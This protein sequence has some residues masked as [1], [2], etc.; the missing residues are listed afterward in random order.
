MLIRVG[1]SPTMG[2][3]QDDDATACHRVLIVYASDT[4][5]TAE[6]A[7]R[8]YC[9]Q[10]SDSDAVVVGSAICAGLEGWQ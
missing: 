1:V 10:W 2:G 6:L 8:W 7:N 9:Y 3:G 4:G 5:N